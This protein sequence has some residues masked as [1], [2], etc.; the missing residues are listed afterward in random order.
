LKILLVT[1]IGRWAWKHQTRQVISS[2]LQCAEEVAM[3]ALV[4][5][6]LT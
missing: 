4:L 2:S 1:S 5:L 6:H 3:D